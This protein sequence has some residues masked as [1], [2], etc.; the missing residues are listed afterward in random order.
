M[1]KRNLA[2]VGTEQNYFADMHDGKMGSD[3]STVSDCASPEDAAT[4]YF[5]NVFENS[6]ARIREAVIGVWLTTEGPEDA[7]IFEAS[8]T[9]T[10]CTEPD[11]EAGEFDII[12]DVRERS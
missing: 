3:P 7:R 12:L 4:S 10:P 5:R 11:A 9:M 1:G 2:I 8:A 6:N